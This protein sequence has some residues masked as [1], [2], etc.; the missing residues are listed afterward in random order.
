M[1]NISFK[2]AILILVAVKS[3]VLFAQSAASQFGKISL[4]VVMPENLEGLSV[5]QLGQ[6][7]TKITSIVTA[8]GLAATG[9]SRNFVIFPK[10][11]ITKSEVYGGGMQDIYNIGGQITLIIKQTV[12]NITFSTISKD[13]AA[14]G[15]GK[16]E[17]ITNAI[18][19]LNTNDQDF[20]TF[21]QTAKSKIIGYYESTCQDLLNK[22]EALTKMG[23]YPQAIGMMM[24]VPEEVSCYSKALDKAVKAYVAYKNANCSKK[25]LE[26]KTMLAQNDYSGAMSTLSEIDPS[27]SCYKEVDP[28]IKKAEAKITA[29]ER[30]Q[31]QF[32]MQVYKDAVA[33]EKQRVNAVKDIAVA[34]YNSQPKTVNYNTLILY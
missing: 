6:I 34:Y 29:E 12:N 33:L 15:R 8:N 24:S 22:S 9:Y 21:I 25:V 19:K 4:S 2:I 18:S 20:Q 32:Q 5:K 16:A 28:L 11:E 30:K 23:D 7:E 3:S 13:F 14:S 17:A 31:W 27:A 26:A 10:F 1:K